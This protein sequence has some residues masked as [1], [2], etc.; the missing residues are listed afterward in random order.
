MCGYGQN[1]DAVRT[2]LRRI[3]GQARGLSRR[4]ES[5]TTEGRRQR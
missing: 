1:K 4:V 3:A 2:R 5:D